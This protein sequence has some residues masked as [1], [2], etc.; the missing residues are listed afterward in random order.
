MAGSLSPL[1]RTWGAL[2]AQLAGLSSAG[3]GGLAIALIV[4]VACIDWWTGVD[5][6][7]SVFYLLPVALVAWRLG[8]RPGIAASLAAATTWGSLDWLGGHEYPHPAYHAWNSG[9]RFG[10]FIITTLLLCKL[11]DA[12]Q[13]QVDL[14]RTDALTGAA[15]RRTLLEALTGEIARSARTGRPF[16]FVCADLDGFKAINDT[17]GHPTGDAVLREI[18]TVASERLR[19]TDLFA[20]MGGDEFGLLLPETGVS[21]AQLVL[22]DLRGAFE[23]ALRREKW[24]VGLSA[25]AVTFASVPGTAEE[26]IRL[27]DLL[28]LECKAQQKG[29]TVFAVATSPSGLSLARVQ[30]VR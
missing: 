22:V 15:N 25:G 19:Q 29:T 12:Y 24:S 18:V 5:L 23:S 20:R 13:R 7:L 9:V 11:R 4:I 3:A 28:L 17:L 26:A 16:T 2:S 21:E 27:A 10:F 8:L 6:A 30:E 14:A 1:G